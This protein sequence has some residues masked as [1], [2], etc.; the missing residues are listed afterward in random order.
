MSPAVFTRWLGFASVLLFVLTASTM[1]P[2]RLATWLRTQSRL[3]PADAIVVLGGGGAWPDGQLSNVSLRRALQGVLLYRKGLAPLVLFSGA[4]SRRHP[5]EA[6]A[7]ADLA[8]ELGLPPEAILTEGGSFTTR[9]EA[10]RIWALLSGRG[11]RKILLVTDSQHLERAERLFAGVGFTV[12]PAA[13]DDFSNDPR[14][15]EARLEL[16]RRTAEEILAR[17]YYRLAGHL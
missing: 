11:V 16:M 14:T 17:F 3:E 5:T 7:R 2:N 13:A 12:L 10:A 6:E 15:S 4:P 1:L 9:H 8:R